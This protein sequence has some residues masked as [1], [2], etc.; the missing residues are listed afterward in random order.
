MMALSLLFFKVPFNNPDMLFLPCG[1]G[2]EQEQAE[3]PV[4]VP[5]KIM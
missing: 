4:A 3:N 5:E 2:R 1:P